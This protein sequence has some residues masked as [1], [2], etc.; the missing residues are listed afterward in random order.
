MDCAAQFR[1]SE[2][3]H[4]RH[5]AYVGLCR[6]LHHYARVYQLQVSDKMECLNQNN[7]SFCKYFNF[8]FLSCQLNASQYFRENFMQILRILVL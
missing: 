8:P 6:V 1:L 2:P 3:C 4:G 5:E 7:C